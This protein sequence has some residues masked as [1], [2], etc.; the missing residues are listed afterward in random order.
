MW[1]IVLKEVTMTQTRL[2]SCSRPRRV[3]LYEASAPLRARA[4][5]V[6]PRIAGLAMRAP[7]E[8]KSNEGATS[9]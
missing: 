6:D 1:R 4:V 3:R 7:P 8:E 2:P 9:L 5:A